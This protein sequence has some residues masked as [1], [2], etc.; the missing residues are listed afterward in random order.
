MPN[1]TDATGNT[2]SEPNSVLGSEHTMSNTTGNI[3]IALGTVLVLPNTTTPELPITTTP[4]GCL[5]PADATTHSTTSNIPVTD[6]SFE[7]VSEPIKVNP[8]SVNHGSDVIAPSKITTTSNHKKRK[9]SK[10]KGK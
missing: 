2:G 10:K 5:L 7:L 8:T 9:S 3:L 1:T 4:I 6:P